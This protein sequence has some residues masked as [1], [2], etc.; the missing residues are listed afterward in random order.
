MAIQDLLEKKSI[1]QIE[2]IAESAL[3]ESVENRVKF[4]SVL[5]FLE[6]TKRFREN[7]QFKNETFKNYITIKYLLPYER[8]Y[9]ERLAY[10]K[11]PKEVETYGIG[12]VVK[13]NKQC[14][15]LEAPKVFEELNRKVKEKQ[16]KQKVTDSQPVVLAQPEIDAVI[17]KHARPKIE[18][19]QKVYTYAQLERMYQKTCEENKRLLKKLEE[20]KAREEKLKGALLILKEDKAA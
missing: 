15:P 12:N 16:K 2:T 5:Y 8:Y 1:E 10:V 20:L 13:V 19:P 4:I 6:R 14:S 9:Q 3:K 11:T 17:K 18:I 7:K